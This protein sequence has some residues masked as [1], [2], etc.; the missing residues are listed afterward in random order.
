MPGFAELEL[1]L[2]RRD[3]ETCTVGFRF[4]A[5][6]EEA[7]RI[8]D[9]VGVFAPPAL[10]RSGAESDPAAYGR[11]LSHA[12]FADPGAAGHFQQFRAAAPP[13]GLRLRLILPPDLQ[14]YRWETILDPDPGRNGA[15]LFAGGNVYLS[16]YLGSTHR[17]AART[18]PKAALNALIAVADVA[19]SRKAAGRTLAPIDVEG[20]LARAQAALKP[21]AARA[22]TQGTTAARLFEELRHGVDVLYLVC[23]GALIDGEPRLWLEPEDP[24]APFEPLAGSE[25]LRRVGD[26]PQ[27]PRLIVLAS[28]QSAGSTRDDSVLAALGPRLISEAGAGAVLA[29]QGNIQMDTV[30]ILMPE[31]FR[32]LQEHDGQ[33]DRALAHARGVARDR[34]CPDYWMPA[35]Y[36]RLQ[37]GALWYQ[38]GFASDRDP[39][40]WD[41]LR[42]FVQGGR[43]L[44]IIGPDLAEHIYGSTR[45][46]AFDLAREAGFPLSSQDAADLAKVSQYLCTR[47]LMNATR[48]KVR[49]LIADQFFANAPS[50][51]KPGA[52]PSLDTVAAAI[53]D[54]PDDPLRIAASLNASVYVTASSDPLFEQVLRRRGKDVVPLVMQWRD[55]RR[56][57]QADAN[58]GE[59][60]FTRAQTEQFQGEDSPDRPFL[61]YIFGKRSQDQEATW[62]LTEDDVFDYLIQTSKYDLIPQAVADALG[63]RALLFLGFSLDDWKFRVLF[64]MILAIEGN[65]QLG[66]FKHVGVQVDPDQATYADLVRAKRYLEDYFTAPHVMRDNLVKPKISIYW[67]TAADFLRQLNTRLNATPVPSGSRDV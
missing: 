43:C 11:A 1:H 6:S 15:P 30:E 53:L 47:D 22:L 66:Q 40:D 49:D 34:Q 10:T 25:F 21:I 28:C 9:N 57:A 52:E 45:N 46:L 27:A 19:Q 31:F 29:M 13:D 56:L 4:S 59:V 2:Q 50:L 44:P 7:L 41:A 54:R 8:A 18:R 14:S 39:F 58:T 3:S 24:E 12:L 16:R 60:S 64:R 36:T 37:N 48:G 38:P 55:E 63:S 23:H 51:L 17:R 32:A 61:Y 5:P 62:V 65:A 20:E 26:L 67:G 42:R 33:I 35:L